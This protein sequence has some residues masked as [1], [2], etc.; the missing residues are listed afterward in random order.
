MATKVLQMCNMKSFRPFREEQ[1]LA[2]S[3][4]MV[5]PI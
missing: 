1:S 4:G 3:M 2:V 5:D